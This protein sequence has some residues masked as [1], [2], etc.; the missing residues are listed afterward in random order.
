MNGPLKCGW[1]CGASFYQ[2]EEREAHEKTCARRA[3]SQGTPAAQQRRAGSG[4]GRAV[5]GAPPR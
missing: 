5:A 1:G 2:G 3:A 4:Q